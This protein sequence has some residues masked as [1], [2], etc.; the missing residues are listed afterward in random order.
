MGIPKKYILFWF[1]SCVLGLPLVVS[2][3][4]V[5]TPSLSTKRNA[6]R[7]F[8]EDLTHNTS[9]LGRFCRSLGILIRSQP[10]FALR[11][12][13]MQVDCDAEGVSDGCR[14]L[15]AYT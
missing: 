13:Y 8:N 6:I 2:T 11:L 4:P 14:I 12:G 10:F 1:F 9:S 15:T 5:D 3:F 7:S